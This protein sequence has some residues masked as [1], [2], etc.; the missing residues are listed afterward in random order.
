MSN[1]KRCPFCDEIMT[2]H[3][4]VCGA[5]DVVEGYGNKKFKEQPYNREGYD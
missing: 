3:L 1:G 5:Y 4:C 2:G